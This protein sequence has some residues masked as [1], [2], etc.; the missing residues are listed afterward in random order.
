AFFREEFGL[1]RETV[2]WGLGALAFT[3]GLLHVMWLGY[4]FL[5]E[6]DYWAGTFGLV[7]VAF[8]EV[9]FFVWLFGPRNAWN[10]IHDGADIRIPRIFRFIMTFVTPV[11]LG[12]ILVWW[13]ISDALPILL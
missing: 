5:D 10:S 13:G 8:L 3:L 9:V 6:W 2:T 11:Y 7:V 1:R 4:G 12:F